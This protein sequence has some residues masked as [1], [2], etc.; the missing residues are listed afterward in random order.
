MKKKYIKI[1][2]NSDNDL[3]LKEKLGY[4]GIIIVV[5]PTFNEGNKYTSQVLSNYC[6]YKFSEKDK[7][8]WL[9]WNWCLR[10]HRY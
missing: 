7:N 2:F 4:Y 3:S 6:W 9:W 10:K 1:K 8:D 5:R